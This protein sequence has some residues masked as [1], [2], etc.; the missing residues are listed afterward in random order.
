MIYS[1]AEARMHLLFKCAIF[2]LLYLMIGTSE[3]RSY[4]VGSFCGGLREA[5]LD[6]SWA[7]MVGNCLSARDGTFS[8]SRYR[9]WIYRVMLLDSARIGGNP[10]NMRV[11]T[12]QKANSRATHNTG[13][14]IDDLGDSFLMEG[15]SSDPSATEIKDF[16]FS[17]LR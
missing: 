16:C 5:I 15:I 11:Q 17:K 1:V 13:I 14:N 4:I 8:W 2:Q 10:R 3:S 12:Y 9:A 7:K 6:R